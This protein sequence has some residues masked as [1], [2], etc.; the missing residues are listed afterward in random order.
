MKYLSNIDLNKNELQNARLQNLATHPANPVPGQIYFNTVDNTFYGWSGS[1]WIDL[2]EILTGE[3]VVALINASSDRIADKNLSTNVNDALSKRHSH[4]NQ[5]I[6]D[7]IEQP[8]KTTDKSKLDGISPGANKVEGSTNGRIKIDGTDVTVYT[9][10]GSGTNPHGTTKGD[11]GLGNVENKNSATI[12]SELTS[13]N[14]TNALNF[15]PIKDGGST[16]ELR[17]G[18]EGTRPV[19]TGSG[20]VYF[21]TDTKRIW[22][23]TGVN[24]W[25]QMGGQD[26]IDWSSIT[27]KPSTFTPPVASPTLLGGVKVG[28]NLSITAD[29]T[30]NANDN[31]ASFIRKQERF[32]VGNGQTVFNLTKGTY[33]PNT[34]A[35]TWFLN[36]DKQ[37]DRALT[38]TSSTSVTLPTGLPEGSEILFEYY[39]VINWHPFPTHA[40]EH[41]TE[42]ADPIPKAT[43]SSDGL[44]PKEDKVKLDGIEAGA[45]KYVHP[46][47]HPASMITEDTSRRFVSDTEKATW[48]A[49]SNLAL[50]ETSATAYRGDRGKIAY[51]HSQAA[52]APSNAQ[53]NSDI[54]KAE[55]EAKLTG[56][57]N[58]HNHDGAYEP[59][60]ANIQSHISSTNNPHNVTKAQ[61]G[62]GNVENKSSAT[63]RGEITS[64]NVTTALGYTPEDASKKG[65]ANG[66]A[67]LDANAKVPLAQLPDAAKQQTY[68]VLNA[69]A[70]NA[71]TGLF[72]GDKAFETSTGDSYIWNGSTW[73]ILA[74]ADWENVNLQ[75]SNINGKPS[76]SVANIDDA[77]N[78]RHSHSNKN[79]LDATTASFTTALNTK[80]SGIETGAQVNTVTSVAGKTGVVTVTKSDVGLS[81][82][83]NVK[84]ATKTEFD[85]HA[86]ATN[87]P[88]NVTK[89]QIGLG[90][91]E[92]KSSA[93]IRGE[94][95][96]EDVTAGLGYT[97][98][99]KAGDEFEG[100]VKLPASTSSEAPLNIPHGTAPSSPENGDLW[101]TT[102]G[103]LARINGATRTLAHTSQWSEITVAEAEGGTSSTARFISGRRLKSAIDALSP[104]KSVAGKSGDVTL[105]KDDVE[106]GN[107]DNVQQASKS[108]FDTHNGDSTRHITS[109]ERTNWNAKTG[110]FA[111]NIGNGSATAITLT[112]NLNTLDITVSVRE[113][114]TNQHVFCDIETVNSNSIRLLFS[115]APS[116]NQFR[117]TVT[118]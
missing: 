118:G 15:T 28:A 88:H 3:A 75:W 54:T 19:A 29:G 117:A 40:N 48:N 116:T 104:V 65:A 32:T 21:A 90:D 34:G 94:I 26:S 113:V 101:T 84:Q 64:N 76:S 44:Y 87:N 9:H 59:A 93:T 86:T 56:T 112:H 63:I 47:N 70:R 103:L 6:L 16:P 30:L 24:T 77:V 37:D 83:D 66:Y 5:T 45:N 107:V 13:Q 95:T 50:G 39:E 33:K 73:I 22:K 80:L 14:V 31:P 17:S 20:I 52:H 81:N 23:D 91:V 46:A 79:V 74:K 4:S 2:G 58:T 98:A 11:V 1:G 67:G 115:Q 106:L 55:I 36:G 57:V 38:E 100:K 114:A 72:S 7:G 61:V 43:Q 97:P 69:T 96:K 41:L 102:S 42:G 12:R 68:V 82:V 62:L 99:D 10:P 105:N 18:S 60:N 25:T 78:Q 51:D 111:A 53:K 89:A 92:N 27:G 109:T 71:L 85:N 49:K 8:F 35:M 110:K 108:E